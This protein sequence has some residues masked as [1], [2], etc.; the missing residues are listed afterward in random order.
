MRHEGSEHR[1]PGHGDRDPRADERARPETGSQPGTRDLADAGKT[2]SP[3]T[4][5]QASSPA[6]PARPPSLPHPQKHADARTERES[7][8]AEGAGTT[9]ERSGTTAEGAGTRHE[10]PRGLPDE[11]SAERLAQEDHALLEPGDA[12]DFRVK[13]QEIQSDFVDHPKDAVREADTLVAE[14]MRTLAAS[15]ASRK[16]G[17]ERQWAQGDDVVT[18]DLRIALQRYRSF[19]N[20]LLSA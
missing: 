11:S 8:A 12:K 18:E 1:D 7:G 20:R 5:A 10:P 9:A 14:V 17:L 4:A 2:D 3:T 16:D 13:W 6:R 19:F 15:F